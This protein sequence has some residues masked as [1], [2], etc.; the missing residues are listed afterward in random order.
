MS[1]SPKFT[2][3]LTH[4]Q[5]DVGLIKLT[6]GL[7][8]TAK[9]VEKNDKRGVVLAEG[10]ATGHYHVIADKE[11]V[12]VYRNENDEMLL[13]VISN[14]TLTHIGN[15]H[16]IVPLNAGDVFRVFIQQEQDLH[17]HIQD[18]RD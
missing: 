13:K 6:E 8:A 5:G 7:P 1:K 4:R 14:T 17:G 3:I 18:V 12:E 15:D 9:R 16:D 11:A 2:E 10:E